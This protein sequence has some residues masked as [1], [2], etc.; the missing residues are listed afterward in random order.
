MNLTSPT[1]WESKA[2]VEDVSA[3]IPED[4]VS[5]SVANKEKNESRK[6]WKTFPTEMCEHD[7]CY[8]AWV[9]ALA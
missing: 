9:S 8:F 2:V 1:L 3:S 4:S 5:R 6:R 7:R